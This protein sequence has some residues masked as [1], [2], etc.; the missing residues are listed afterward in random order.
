MDHS[1]SKS[2]AIEDMASSRALSRS[3]MPN[4]AGI[5]MEGDMHLFVQYLTCIREYMHKDIEK[6]NKT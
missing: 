3:L 1:L 2:L 6:G 4:F 5:G